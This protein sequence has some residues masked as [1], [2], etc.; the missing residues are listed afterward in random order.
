MICPYCKTENALGAT[1]CSACTSWMTERP[2]VREWTRARE[3][4]IVAGISR[5]LSNRF[6]I[7]VAAVRLVFLLS[8]L[9]GGWGILVYVALWI[10]M[11]LE[12]APAA[13]VPAGPPAATASPPAA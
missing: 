9:F 6:G 11:P 7:P 5:G 8:V 12:P 4:R 13:L 3:R 10:A 1:R 2:P